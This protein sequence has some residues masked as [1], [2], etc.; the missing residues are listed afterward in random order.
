MGAF[1]AEHGDTTF[2][3][4]PDGRLGAPLVKL[5]AAMHRRAAEAGLYTF[6]LEPPDGRGL[7]FVDSFYL[8]EEVFRHGLRGQQWLLAWTDGPSPLVGHWSEQARERFLPDFVAGRTAAA[9]AATE[10]GAGSDLKAV[11]T[12]ARRDGE[13]WVLNGA[14]HLIT[15]APFVELAQVLARTDRG[16]ALFLV[17]LDS[18]GVERG[19]VQQTIM[20]DGQTGSLSF[21][22]VRLPGWALMGEDGSGLQLALTWINWART[23]RGGMCSGLARHCLDRSVAYARERETFGRQIAEHGPVATLLAD[24]HMEWEAMRALSLELLARLDRAGIFDGKV[25]REARRDISVVKAWND[26]ALYRIADRALQVG[27]GRGLL[28]DT[29]LE[30]IFRVARNLRIPA[31]PTEIQRQTV[32][33]TLVE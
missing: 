13:G 21:S 1:E 19:P 6:H 25:S 18:P 9:F 3:L 20:A 28:T 15:G 33:R 16:L 27:G 8:Q 29:G 26:E 31:G 10:R 24:M 23:R 30:R 2:L 22:D 14:K 11:R 12:E 17:P 4:E 32:A 5:K 7:S